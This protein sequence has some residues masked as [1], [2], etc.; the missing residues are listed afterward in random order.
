ME[1]FKF[2]ITE[3]HWLNLVNL[4]LGG[5]GF[6][7]ALIVP[8]LALRWPSIP[9]SLAWLSP[10]IILIVAAIAATM[11]NSTV[12]TA[13]GAASPE[14]KQTLVAAGVS[15]AMSAGTLAFA[16]SGLLLLFT[17][18]TSLI[19][20]FRAGPEAKLDLAGVAFGLGGSTLGVV[21]SFGMF[22][23][24]SGTDTL[25]EMGMSWM[26]ILGVTA[27]AS[28]VS[29][30]ASSRISSTDP[31]A[32][33]LAATRRLIIGMTGVLAVLMWGGYFEMDGLRSA[34]KATAYA[35]SEVKGT[36]L[37]AGRAV[38]ALSSSFAWALAL[39]PLVGAICSA[40]PGIGQFTKRH[41]GVLGLSV[42][43]G[44][45]L[46]GALL[47]LNAAINGALDPLSQIL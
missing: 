44:L 25:R 35:P 26:V 19:P 6:L 13:M 16:L 7:L 47:A 11:A 34:F 45:M 17:G 1:L 30:V 9:S 8:L 33:G 31:E 46:I 39:A 18:F 40:I 32:R 38:A 5:V 3:G 14:T 41:M 12:M 21:C 28:V 37:T 23:A 24:F 27:L 20:A 29:V 2:I 4:P 42:L 22:L 10:L 36:L 43:L 15:Q